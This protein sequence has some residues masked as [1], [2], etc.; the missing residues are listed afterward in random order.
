MPPQTDGLVARAATT[1]KQ[2]MFGTTVSS[3]WREGSPNDTLKGYVEER[4][5][6]AA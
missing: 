4:G 5:E 2:Y 3:D 1:I 6:A